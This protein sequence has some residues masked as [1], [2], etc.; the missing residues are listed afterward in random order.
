VI[1]IERYRR[2]A[3][4]RLVLAGVLAYK[5]LGPLAMPLGLRRFTGRVVAASW[6]CGAMDALGSVGTNLTR[7]HLP[8]LLGCLRVTTHFSSHSRVDVAFSG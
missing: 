1:T 3:L 5:F 4:V 6:P 2:A 8:V 7:W